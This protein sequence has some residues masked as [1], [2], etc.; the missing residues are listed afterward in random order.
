MTKRLPTTKARPSERNLCFSAVP[1]TSWPTEF[2]RAW[3]EGLP[4]EWGQS[5]QALYRRAYGLFRAYCRHVRKN[6]DHSREAISAYGRYL[7]ENAPKRAGQ[8][9]FRLHVA[10]TVLFAAEDWSWLAQETRERRAQFQPPRL[11]TNPGPRSGDSL[12]LSFPDWPEDDRERWHRGLAPPNPA[13]SRLEYY[14][15]RRLIEVYRPILAGPGVTDEAWLSRE[16]GPLSASQLQR[17]IRRATQEELGKP[18][19]LHLFRD[20]LATTVS[21]IAPERIEDAARIL[22]HRQVCDSG[23]KF[24]PQLPAIEFYR[25]VSA[26][27]LAG[28][29]LAALQEPYRMHRRQGKRRVNEPS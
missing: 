16:G 8:K 29:K 14:T 5:Q 27:A 17:R 10:L 6:T 26:T 25:Q 1:F 9:L 2:R 4:P 13:C 11:P 7:Y 20:C 28:Q 22:G 21:E 24:G 15:E 18:I 3:S 23:R 19:S 12:S